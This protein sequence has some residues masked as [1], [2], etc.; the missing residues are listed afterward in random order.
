MLTYLRRG[1][2]RPSTSL[3][4]IAVAAALSAGLAPAFAQTPAE[5]TVVLDKEPPTLEPCH[6][7][8]GLVGRVVANN[9]SESLL[10]RDPATGELTP[11]L[12][13]GWEQLDDLTWRFKLREG[14]TFHDGSPFNAEVAKYSVE[15]SLNPTLLCETYNKF[16]SGMK[17]GVTAVDDYTLDIKSEIPDPIMPLRMATVTMF[18]KDLPMDARVT[19][20]VGT[21][22]YKMVEWLPGQSIVVER[23]P[24]YWGEKPAVEKATFVW[25]S[26]SSVRAAMVAQGEADLAPTISIQDFDEAKGA[27]YPNSE[28]IRLQL[29]VIMPPM[30]DIRVRA[31]INYAIDRDALRGTVLSKDSIPATQIILPQIN[32]Y[33]PDLKSWP[34]NPEL[35]KALIEDARA[36]GVPVDR[37]IAFYGRNGHFE[38]VLETQQ[39]ITQMLNDIGLNVTLQMMDQSQMGPK[40]MK[41]FAE[42]RPPELIVDQHDNNRGDAVFSVY[43]KYHSEGVFSRTEDP[44]LDFLIDTATSQTGEERTKTWQKAFDRIENGLIADAMLFHMVGYAAVGPRINYTPNLAT[45]SEVT[46]SSISFK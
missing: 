32:G 27:S 31:A 23:F 42:N 1:Q 25:R 8:Q 20:G 7:L 26:E 35:A 11:V 10:K 44:Y 29:D 19:Q 46:L 4:A 45:N 2:F 22:P 12:A 40:Q 34:F 3:A 21:G 16:F 17:L 9:L 41:P 13:T 43:G 39:A 24:N 36:D 28:T 38:G 15:R 37:E 18:T 5:V 6:A 33:N 30:D 14:V